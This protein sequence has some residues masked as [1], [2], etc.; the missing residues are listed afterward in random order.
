MQKSFLVVWY[1]TEK[2]LAKARLA[3]WKDGEDG[4]LDSY[5]PE[6]DPK[7]ADVK[8]FPTLD[9]AVA[10][11]KPMC[12][13]ENKLFWRQGNIREFEVGG[14][15]CKYCTCRGRRVVHEYVVE[16]EGVVEDFSRDD[17]AD[18]ED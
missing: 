7:G 11:L 8:E 14:R 9:A 16:E 1:D 5:A 12:A 3:G 10:F 17:C 18:G 13:D 15:R 2:V 4:L 6:E